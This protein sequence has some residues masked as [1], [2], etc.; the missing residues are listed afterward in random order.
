M[1]DM[2]TITIISTKYEVP[3]VKHK[4]EESK[5]LKKFYV[6][7]DRRYCGVKDFKDKD[8]EEWVLGLNL[9]KRIKLPFEKSNYNDDDL[10]FL[11][12][13][14]KDHS[15]EIPD[16]FITHNYSTFVLHDKYTQIEDNVYIFPITK[17]IHR[18]TLDLKEHVKCLVKFAHDIDNDSS[19][20]L[21]LHYSDY[22]LKLEGVGGIYPL[23]SSE[24][25]DIENVN[26]FLFSHVDNC[27]KKYLEAK[28]KNEA[29][30]LTIEQLLLEIDCNLKE[31]VIDP[32]YEAIDRLP[33]I[34][35]SIALADFSYL[36]K[37]TQ[38]DCNQNDKDKVFNVIHAN[39]S[40]P[41]VEEK[42]RRILTEI[43]HK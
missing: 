24:Y 34:K 26:I 19:I 28:E 4:M 21:M 5:Y 8:G 29:N 25:T 42:Y 9:D 36:N 18:H 7:D 14:C 35:D 1:Q 41:D 13:S 10:R 17:E 40:N 30:D 16:R 38:T 22:S 12:D 39:I 43:L 11:F 33:K 2:K 32:L 31:V 23:E 20:C 15:I 27:I 6:K 3:G 37:L